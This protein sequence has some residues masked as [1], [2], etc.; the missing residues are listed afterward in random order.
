MRVGEERTT[1]KYKLKVS[2]AFTLLLFIITALVAP[3]SATRPL[4]GEMELQFN[5]GWPGP[6]EVEPVWVGTVTI[7]DHEYGMA[8]FN[9]GTGKPFDAPPS[10]SVSFFEETWT[11]YRT[12]SFEFNDDGT[13]NMDE[14]EPGEV[15]LSGYDRGVFSVANSKYRMNGYV[16]VA[17]DDF[18]ERIGSRVHMSGVLEYADNGAPQYAPGVIRI[19]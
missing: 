17:A 14:W 10:D 19:N 1:M 4:V 8:F 18:E 3:A 12:L 6:G 2:V 5:P 13:L 11:I 15:V 16:E 7:D 9:T